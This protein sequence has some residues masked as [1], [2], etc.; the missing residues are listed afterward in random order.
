MLLRGVTDVGIR[1][2]FLLKLRVGVHD[3]VHDT[4]LPCSCGMTYSINYNV[5]KAFC[6]W[7]EIVLNRV[8]ETCKGFFHL[9]IMA[10]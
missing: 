10:R 6:A 4:L 3:C 1:G 2:E 9:C 7:H 5:L 8:S